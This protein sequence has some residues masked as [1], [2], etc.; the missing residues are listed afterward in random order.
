VTIASTLPSEPA[1]LAAAVG[2]YRRRLCLARSDPQ[3]VTSARSARTDTP[4]PAR[5][6]RSKFE[7]TAQP[8]AA[9]R[10]PATHSRRL[11][12]LLLPP[13]PSPSPT[14]D[15]PRAE[16]QRRRRPSSVA[17]HARSVAATKIEPVPQE[18]VEYDS[19]APLAY[20]LGGGG[21]DARRR[22]GAAALGTSIGMRARLHT[23]MN[24]LR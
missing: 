16:Q 5:P 23:S 18:R 13:L 21:R 22:G 4:A 3:A 24:E 6:T 7:G 20:R 12:L 17:A 19:G 2:A 9:S 15:A 8:L 1:M 10:S 11:S 14:R